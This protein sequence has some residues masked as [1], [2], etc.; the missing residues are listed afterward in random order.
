MSQLNVAELIYQ[1]PFLLALKRAYPNLQLDI[2]LDNCRDTIK[3]SKARPGETF[4]PW[5]LNTGITDAVFPRAKDN[6]DRESLIRQARR[7][8][9][10]LVFYFAGSRHADFARVACAIAPNA[11]MVGSQP[12][13]R[14]EQLAAWP[15]LRNVTHKYAYEEG[16][17]NAHVFDQYRDVYQA[18]FGELNLSNREQAGDIFNLPQGACDYVNQWLE[19]RGLTQHSVKI[20]L[21]PLSSTRWRDMSG[22]LIKSLI[23]RV[24]KQNADVHLIVHVPQSSE[25]GIRALLGDILE[26]V[27]HRV[28]LFVAT[29]DVFTLPAMIARCDGVITVETS[30]M[31]LASSLHKP[32]LVLMRR[33]M[34]TWQPL[35]AHGIIWCGD[36]IRDT[37][38]KEVCDKAEAWLARALI[39]QDVD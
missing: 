11:T 20:L 16:S 4:K 39:Q 33:K 8:K 18:C 31:H 5:L 22:S 9:Y 38:E 7:R 14:F 37:D 6:S 10:D 15:A 1:G 13:R 28:S 17:V 3:A 32:Q 25:A 24:H 2:W 21:N 29:D 12:V 19:Q 26:A 36:D 34:R 30:V 27:N 23:D 35:N